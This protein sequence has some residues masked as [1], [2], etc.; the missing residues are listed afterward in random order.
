METK[1]ISPEQLNKI[2]RNYEL[3]EKYDLAQK[4]YLEAAQ[5][6]CKEAQN[7]VG[8]RQ[9]HGLYGFVQN[10]NEAVD[11]YKKSHEQGYPSA[12]A[13]LARCFYYGIGGI[14]RNEIEAKKL[15]EKAAEAGN[16][17]AIK[18][19]EKQKEKSLYIGQ[20]DEVENLANQGDKSS[21]HKLGSRYKHGQGGRTVDYQKAAYWFDKAAKQDHKESLFE[22]G[23]LYRDGLGVKKDVS[24]AKQYLTKAKN[25]GHSIAEA[26]L[27]KI[28]REQNQTFAEQI[29]FGEQSTSANFLE[30]KQSFIGAPQDG[31]LAF[32]LGV[33]ALSGKAGIDDFD[34]I[35]ALYWFKQ[36]RELKYEWGALGVALIDISDSDALKDASRNLVEAHNIRRGTNIA[37]LSQWEKIFLRTIETHTSESLRYKSVITALLNWKIDKDD[38]RRQIEDILKDTKKCSDE[39]DIEC[40]IQALLMLVR[41]GIDDLWNDYD[42]K[43][44]EDNLNE[45]VSEIDKTKDQKIYLKYSR[46]SALCS[47][48]FE[49]KGKKDAKVN[50]EK[51]LLSLQHHTLLGPLS[52]GL[53][54]ISDAKRQ[55]LSNPQYAERN[56]DELKM[57]LLFLK[58]Q[59]ESHAL[60][61]KSPFEFWQS[62]QNN[63]GEDTAL[64]KIVIEAIIQAV[65]RLA[66][67]K[68]NM[69]RSIDKS[70]AYLAISKIIDT[71]S[72]QLNC[73]QYPF[74]YIELDLEQSKNL[75]LPIYGVG[76][77][78]M[79]SIILE[80]V[81]NALKHENGTEAVKIS[82]VILEGNFKF[83]VTNRCSY[84]KPFISQSSHR[85]LYHLRRLISLLEDRGAKM[86][87]QHDV[88][89]GEFKSI[90]SLPS[91]LFRGSQS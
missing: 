62:W 14:E 65:C 2:A 7:N 39:T 43:E 66:I 78:F 44:I 59:I 6:G 18:Q 4:H 81:F 45:L 50:A 42:P 91:Q 1:D 84:E 87:F 86:E 3:Q 33:L 88:D 80:L 53:S 17:Y 73:L 27:N 79:F 72:A 32:L 64:Y 11:W 37:D 21:Q 41:F 26:T 36:A 31:K 56:I 8:Y 10:K 5:R 16:P 20:Y 19:L 83:T 71:K 63:S 38:C 49:A 40:R 82:A 48:D 34:P 74:D 60:L 57:S 47:A 61:M 12:T 52:K 30:L 77:A 22:L 89:S 85:G 29:I 46:L 68:F 24:L 9:E 15:W 76:S 28:K 25:K 70:D 75:S 13:N 55:I 54:L 23:I 69:G 58:N 67:S 51:E 90:F 35:N